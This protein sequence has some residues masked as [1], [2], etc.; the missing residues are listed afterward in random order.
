MFT[1]AD[2]FSREVWVY[3]LWHKNEAFPMFKKFKAYVENYTRKRIK[4][5]MT[6]NGLE[7]YE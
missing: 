2:A 4:K 7:F 6:D 1:F 5:L 3:F